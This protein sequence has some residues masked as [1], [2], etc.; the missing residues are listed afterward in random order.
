ML[1][2]LENTIKTQKEQISYLLKSVTELQADANKPKKLCYTVKEACE[3]TGLKKFS[4]LKYI[5]DGKLKAVKGDKNYLINV[6]SL[7]VLVNANA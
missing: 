5:H 6:E 3:A 4:I 7:K 1:Q 2:E